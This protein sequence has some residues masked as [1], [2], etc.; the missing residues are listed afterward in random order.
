MCKGQ[1][2]THYGMYRGTEHYTLCSI[3]GNLQG[4]E[5]YRCK[6]KKGNREFFECLLIGNVP[7][8]YTPMLSQIQHDEKLEWTWTEL[9]YFDKLTEVLNFTSGLTECTGDSAN[10]CI[11]SAE[12]ALRDSL[13]G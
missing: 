1:K 5:H 4:M 11:T 12:M 13:L 8:L 9:N 3:L 6:G 7:S 2:H 10:I